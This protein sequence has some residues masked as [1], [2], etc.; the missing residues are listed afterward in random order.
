MC[1]GQSATGAGS[2]CYDIPAFHAGS[3]E[4][5]LELTIPGSEADV[6]LAN[7]WETEVD[8]RLGSTQNSKIKKP[9]FFP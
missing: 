5:N 2:L 6:R 3:D 1:S 4:S 7:L 9:P 8:G